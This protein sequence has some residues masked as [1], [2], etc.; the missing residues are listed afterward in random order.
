M[1]RLAEKYLNPDVP[2]IITGDWNL[3]HHLWD[4]RVEKENVTT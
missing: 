3:H 2:T 1:D 4:L